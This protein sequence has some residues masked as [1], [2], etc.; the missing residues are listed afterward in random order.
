MGSSKPKLKAEV[1]LESAELI[2]FQRGGEVKVASRRRGMAWMRDAL[3]ASDEKMSPVHVVVTTPA[4][5]VETV[6]VLFVGQLTMMRKD[7]GI[8]FSILRRRAWKGRQACHAGM[9]AR[10]RSKFVPLL[11]ESE[12]FPACVHLTRKRLRPRSV[13]VAATLTAIEA[14]IA[15][16]AAA[17][18]FRSRGP[19]PLT[20]VGEEGAVV[21]SG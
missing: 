10:M 19:M 2:L 16:V 20:K 6:D 1:A 8:S 7:M 13:G 4:E 3:R 14:E 11:N 17:G 9:D 18:E 21:W 5:V 15:E 12:R